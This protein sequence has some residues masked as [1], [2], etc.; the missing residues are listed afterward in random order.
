MASISY[1]T[2]QYDWPF[3][4]LGKMKRRGRT[5]T[6]DRLEE[7][8]RV[9]SRSLETK[10]KGLSC[11]L[12]RNTKT[13]LENIVCLLCLSILW[14]RLLLT[15]MSVQWPTLNRGPICCLCFLSHLPFCLL[16]LYYSVTSALFLLFIV[17]HAHADVYFW[18]L[19]VV[20]HVARSFKITQISNI[21]DKSDK[22]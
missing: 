2:W 3:L 18:F 17:I 14:W 6:L 12:R 5:M 4:L 8:L 15:K 11:C 13:K 22:Q 19:F 16:F 20:F 9:V 1:A 21:G 7:L 10:R